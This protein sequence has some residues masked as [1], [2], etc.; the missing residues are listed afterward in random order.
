MLIEILYDFI[1]VI[2][3]TEDGETYPHANLTVSMMLDAL[4]CCGLVL[5]PGNDAGMA[6]MD[7]LANS[8]DNEASA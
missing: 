3:V 7:S 8:L 2:D 6:F 4:G 5:Q 1:E